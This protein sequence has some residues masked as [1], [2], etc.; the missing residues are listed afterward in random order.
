MLLW[1]RGAA[2]D[3][4]RRPPGSHRP[5][6][7]PEDD[8]RYRQK[9]RERRRRERAAD[10][11]E[12]RRGHYAG[13]RVKR[14]KDGTLE[15]RATGFYAYIRPDGSLRFSDRRVSWDGRN[16]GIRF[17]I[18]DAVMRRLGD[19]P[20]R[21]RKLKFERETRRLRASLR[22]DWKHRVEVSY[23][24]QLPGRLL[25][26][27]R[28]T[29]LSPAQRRKILFQLWE[30]CLE[31]DA[32]RPGRKAQRARGMILAFIRKHLPRGSAHA[33]TVAELAIYLK[34]RQGRPAFD[35]YGRLAR[36]VPLRQAPPPAPPRRKSR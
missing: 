24:R 19:D 6:I 10:Y 26:L 33:Y 9:E 35:P 14:L 4:T 20:Y 30:E 28:R 23:F 18:T 8:P 1:P 11:T 31:P 16:L 27:W 29:D 21:Y 12:I 32:T 36:V 13:Y 34:R 2:A 5:V 22:A 25:G 17:D 3:P 15:F 7:G